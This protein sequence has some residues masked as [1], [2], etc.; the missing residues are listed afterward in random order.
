M[1][2]RQLFLFLL[3]AAVGYLW[4]QSSRP[5]RYSEWTGE[6]SQPAAEAVLDR[7]FEGVGATHWEFAATGDSIW[8]VSRVL[9]VLGRYRVIHWQGDSLCFRLYV[10]YDTLGVCHNLALISGGKTIRVEPRGDSARFL[11]QGEAVT[12]AWIPW[13]ADAVPYEA[14]PALCDSWWPLAERSITLV[15]IQPQTEVVTQ[16]P[17]QLRV[18]APDTLQLVAGGKTL[19]TIGYASGQAANICL[20]GGRCVVRRKAPP[21]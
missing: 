17:G 1:A 6:Q 21:Q 14:I 18:Q 15:R 19:V 16:L 7:A 11:A 9:D 5:S 8:R 12:D 13:S 4:W 2:R 20:A 3:L 10:D